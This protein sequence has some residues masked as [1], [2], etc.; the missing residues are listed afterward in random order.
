MVFSW[1][2]MVYSEG[3]MVLVRE[4]HG[5]VRGGHGFR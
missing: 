3:S 2:G 5:L 4:V 1:T